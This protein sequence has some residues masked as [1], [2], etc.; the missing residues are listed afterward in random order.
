V[1]KERRHRL[2]AASAAKPAIIVMCRPEIELTG[3]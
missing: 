2:D 1:K 3:L